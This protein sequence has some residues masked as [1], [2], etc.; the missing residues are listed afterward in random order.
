MRRAKKFLTIRN[1]KKLY[2]FLKHYIK[3]V[4]KDEETINT[5]EEAYKEAERVYSYE[6][7]ITP[8]I[9]AEWL[10][11]LPINI[12]YVTYNIVGMMLECITGSSNYNC[13]ENYIEDPVDLDD[14]YW[15]TLGKIIYLE[16]N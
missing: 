15:N 14:F 16:S 8:S 13:L 6:K 1:M 2:T 3:D 9:I 7:Y 11:G 5:F 4:L 12:E 10:R